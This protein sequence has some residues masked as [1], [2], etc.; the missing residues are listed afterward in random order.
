MNL[1][2]PVRASIGLHPFLLLAMASAVGICAHCVSGLKLPGDPTGAFHDGA[3]FR[4]AQS[5]T[6]AR[7]VVLLTDAFGLPYQNC[8]L[9][10]DIYSQR[11]GC[12]VWVPDMFDGSCYRFLVLPHAHIQ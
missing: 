9:L 2:T 3:Y 6:S 4:S 1:V 10:A 11:L 7:A 12:D 8:K 5:T